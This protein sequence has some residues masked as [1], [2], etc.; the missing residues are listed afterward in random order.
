M[1]KTTYMFLDKNV[2]FGFRI[3]TEQR[4]VSISALKGY[5]TNPEEHKFSKNL[6]AT[7]KF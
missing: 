5:V 4:A 6:K 3:Y 2:R 7:S 1:G